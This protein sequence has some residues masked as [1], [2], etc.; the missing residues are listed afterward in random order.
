MTDQKQPIVSFLSG[1]ANSG[2]VKKVAIVGL[3][4]TGKSQVFNN[5]T[6]D[7]AIVA[8][9]PRTTI[10]VKRT[11]ARIHGQS[12]EIIDTP[13]LH[14]F[15]IHSEEEKEVRDMLFSERPDMIVQCIDASRYKQSLLLTADLLELERPMVIVLNAV[16]ESARKGVWFD[17]AELERLL[18]VPVIETVAIRGV[19]KEELKKAIANARKSQAVVSYGH[20]IE[21]A[22]VELAAKLPFELEFKH[23][24]AGLLLLDDSFIGQ[25]LEHRISLTE[26]AQVRDEASKLRREIKANVRHVINAKRSEWGEEVA[27]RVVR[28]KEVAT[29]GFS[30]HLAYASR[31]PVYGIPVFLCF[32]AFVYVS[33]VNVSGIINNFLEAWLVAPV[34]KF[35]TAFSLP[36][37]WNEL[38]IGNHGLLTLGIFNAICTVLPILSVFFFVFALFEDSGYMTN[39]SVFSKRAFEKI[40]VTAK[41]VTSLVLGFGCKTMATLNTKGLGR[42]EKIIAVT[43]I[44]FAIPCSAQLGISLAILGKLGTSAFLIAFGTLILFEI[45]AGILLNTIIKDDGDD[46]FIEAIPPMRIPDMKGVCVKTYYRIVSFLQESVPIFFMSAAVLFALEKAGFLNVM[47]QALSPLIVGWLG[48]PGNIIDVFILALARREAAAGMILKMVEGGSLNYVQSIVAVLVTATSFPCF[49]NI[50]AIRKEMG[51]KTVIVMT[52]LICIASV[53]LAGAF[54]LVLIFFMGGKII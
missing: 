42:K 15:Y 23:K 38:L 43:L 14:S 32:V 7:Y 51:L 9:Y 12:Y 53:I 17:R 13:S 6:G 24:I 21:S 30:Q 16:D 54:R 47:K 2:A 25:Y 27:A 34:V 35:I 29:S 41:A 37:F 31:H 28:L 26:L 8:N 36:P 48:L 4:N 46:A 19:G 3:P 10:E 18:G 33:V 39:F 44:A 5:L 1:S 20:R 52:A 49:A 11:V 45:V 50:V 22:L 40:G